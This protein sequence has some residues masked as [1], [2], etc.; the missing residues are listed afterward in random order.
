[1]WN[2]APYVRKKRRLEKQL[3]QRYGFKPPRENGCDTV[4]SIRAMHRGDIKVLVSMGGNLLSAG[5]DTNFTAE[6]IQACK[7]TAFVA[8]KLNRGLSL[9]GGKCI[10]ANR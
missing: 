4:D 6:A 7:L 8:T 9:P 1:V 2:D 5:P 3:E 10:S